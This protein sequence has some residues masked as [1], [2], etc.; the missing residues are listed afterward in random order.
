MGH[1][2]YMANAKRLTDAGFFA[3]GGYENK[4]QYAITNN[5]KTTYWIY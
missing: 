5:G 1:S 4:T 2:G 3:R